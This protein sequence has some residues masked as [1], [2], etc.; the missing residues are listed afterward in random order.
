[1]VAG[2]YGGVINRAG[3]ADTA[4]LTDSGSLEKWDLY[5]D[6]VQTQADHVWVLLSHRPVVFLP[7]AYGW[8]P[9]ASSTGYRARLS[10]TS[11]WLWLLVNSELV[12]HLIWRCYDMVIHWLFSVEFS[13]VFKNRLCQGSLHFILTGETLF[14]PILVKPESYSPLF[15]SSS[16][17]L[18][19]KMLMG[20]AWGVSP[21]PPAP[22]M[23]CS[24]V[25]PSGC[26]GE[27]LCWQDGRVPIGALK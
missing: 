9:R 11:F 4:T 18:T 7:S 12:I 17:I 8:V 1:M 27:P 24:A 23:P 20:E 15:P 6:D 21:S 22:V 2:L 25:Y 19:Q 26:W 13:K 16:S 5:L 10:S 14:Y 3:W